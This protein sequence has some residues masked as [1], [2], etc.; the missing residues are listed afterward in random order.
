MKLKMLLLP[1]LTAG[2]LGISGIANANLIVNGGFES[3][4]F[5][6]WS[7]SGLTCSGVGAS[8]STASGG[9]FGYDGDPGPHSGAN[10]AYLGTAAGGGVLSQSLA[11]TIGRTYSVDF[12]LAIGAFDGSSTPNSLAVAFGGN[13]LLS[14]TNTAAQGFAHYSYLVTA[15]TA[16]SSLVVTHGNLPSFFILDDVSVNAVPEPATLFLL[17]MG[18][19]GLGFARRRKV[20]I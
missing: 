12:F 7:A 19:A 15:S 9:C 2:L 18:I 6:G 13:S 10:A 14:L 4:S 17:G 1:A 11:T 20:K 5:S 8:F 3:G 16:V